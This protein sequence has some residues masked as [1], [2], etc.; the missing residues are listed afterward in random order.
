MYA[1]LGHIDGM[2]RMPKGKPPLSAA[3]TRTLATWID[4]G[5]PVD[6]GRYWEGLP[7]EGEGEPTPDPDEV[8]RLRLQGIVDRALG[9]L[10]EQNATLQRLNE[11]IDEAMGILQEK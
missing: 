10:D 2:D 6:K 8:E 4:L 11:M 1:D 3:E 5:A 7:P 9:V